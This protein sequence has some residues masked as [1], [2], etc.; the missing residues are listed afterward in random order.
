MDLVAKMVLTVH[1][2]IVFDVPKGELKK[3]LRL[4][5]MVFKN[6]DKYISDYFEVDWNVKLDGECEYG[7]T[8]GSLK[9]V[10][11]ADIV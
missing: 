1:D 4:C 9:A 5:E 7:R 2:S 11:S 10:T 6:L 3:L 8:Y